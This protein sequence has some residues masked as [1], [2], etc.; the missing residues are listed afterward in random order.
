MSERSLDDLL[1]DLVAKYSDRVAR[2]EAPAH[3]PVLQAVPA[4]ARP[5]LERCLKMIDA[6]L[7]QAPSAFQPVVAGMKSMTELL[8]SA[9]N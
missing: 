7:T 3:G 9:T 6:G 8:I 4:E 5:G 1:D 2:G